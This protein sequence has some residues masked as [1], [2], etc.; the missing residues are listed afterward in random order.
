VNDNQD[1]D[2]G[3]PQ[4]DQDRERDQQLLLR[5]RVNL[6]GALNRLSQFFKNIHHLQLGTTKAHDEAA[7]TAN[8]HYS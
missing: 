4:H 1:Q 8:Q 3:H 5:R 7:R 2:T 6:K